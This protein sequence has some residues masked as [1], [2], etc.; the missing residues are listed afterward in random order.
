[1]RVLILAKYGPLAASTRYR[2][3]QFLPDL[4]AAGIDCE[5]SPL[6]DDDYLRERFDGSIFP[7]R[8][9]VG[10][11]FKRARKLL[12]VASFDAAVVYCEL[13]PFL[14]HV[15]EAYLRTK[16][17]P[18]VFDFDDAIQHRYDLSGNPVVRALLGRK[19]HSII[20]GAARVW[21]A[22]DYLADYARLVNPRVSLVPTVIDAG[23][24]QVKRRK[25]GDVVVGWM[26]SPTTAPY[27]GR[28]AAVFRKFLEEP[29]RKV[30]LVG[31]DGLEPGFAAERKPWTLEREVE[32]LQGFD[33]GVMPL[34]DT[35]WERGKSGFKLIQ[36]MACGIPVV[37]SPVGANA[38]IV[39]DGVEGF[40]AESDRDWLEALGRLAADPALRAR[41]GDAGRKK[42]ER[43]YSKTAVLP[44]LIEDLKAAA[45]TSSKATR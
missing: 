5:L 6:F 4:K 13:F 18:Y 36:Y 20:R 3:E 30:T 38:K 31:A 17:V 41:M 43:L 15:F 23:R 29:G 37:A 32:D 28:R 24:Y 16:G 21:A 42:A 34:A 14:P 19:T 40:L 27:V 12:D 7:R 39:E 22:N 25:A 35:P 8:R 2:F 45:G 1:V 10:A 26:G 44:A 11:F 33:V 9:A